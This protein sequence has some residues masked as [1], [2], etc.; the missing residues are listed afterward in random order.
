MMN[1]NL[2]H[3]VYI[4]ESAARTPTLVVPFE[5]SKERVASTLTADD[6]PVVAYVRADSSSSSTL[7]LLLG[8]AR[9][10]LTEIVKDLRARAAL[11]K[12]GIRVRDINLSPAC[13]TAHQ[14]L[15]AAADLYETWIKELDR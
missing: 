10:K 15:S 9:G 5:H 14:A 7:S 6:I 13:A 3:T 2:P 4:F 11:Q 1:K 8:E 12:T